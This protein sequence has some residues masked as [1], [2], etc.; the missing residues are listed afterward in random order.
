ME[1][2]PTVY[3][4]FLCVSLLITYS[5]EPPLPYGVGDWLD[6]VF[7]RVRRSVPFRQNDIADQANQ[8]P[9]SEAARIV[10]DLT[11]PG[12]PLII[13]QN[14]NAKLVV[15]DGPLQILAIAA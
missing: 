10:N 5:S 4:Q 11:D 14:G 7:L 1:F 15:Q 2:A 6:G 8:L 13:T 3:P 9:L 12:E